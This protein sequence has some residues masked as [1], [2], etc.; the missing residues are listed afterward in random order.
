MVLQCMGSLGS[1]TA[2]VH[3]R[4]AFGQRAVD[5]Y[6]TKPDR[7]VALGIGT[8]VPVHVQ[9]MNQLTTPKLRVKV[10][11]LKCELQPTEIMLVTV[12]KHSLTAVCGISR[13]SL[14]PM[15]RH[16]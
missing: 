8:R 7:L 9:T 4:G 2:M 6:G 3:C 15:P 12:W 13:N 11:A 14:P 1:G 10:M 16:L 5:S